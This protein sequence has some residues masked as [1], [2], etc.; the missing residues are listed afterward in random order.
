ML[1]LILD[2][3][4]AA[5]N[6]KCIWLYLNCVTVGMKLA[7]TIEMWIIKTNCKATFK[8][9]PRIP[10]SS[11]DKAAMS[12]S[13]LGGG[14]GVGRIADSLEQLVGICS[15]GASKASHQEES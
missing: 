14:Q 4:K 1:N 8:A 7:K 15:L 2:Y 10:S 6:N 13:S 9:T 11:C 12:A 5:D 3:I